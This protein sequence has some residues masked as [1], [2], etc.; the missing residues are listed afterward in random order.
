[1]LNIIL[2]AEDIREVKQG[3][4]ILVGLSHSQLSIYP[5]DMTGLNGYIITF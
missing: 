2:D 3:I 5:F 4:P 1:M